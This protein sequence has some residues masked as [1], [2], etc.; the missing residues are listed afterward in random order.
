MLK[1]NF[2]VSTI[3]ALL[4]VGCGA[5]STSDGLSSTSTDITVERGPVYG[6]F[7]MDATGNRAVFLGDGK[8]RFTKQVVYPIT[9]DGGYIDVNRNSKID[10]GEIRLPYTLQANK[11]S[12][13]TMA[14]TIASNPQIRT[15]L[16]EEFGLSDEEIDTHTPGSN[17]DIAGLSDEVFAYCV[18]N[19]LT[20]LQF[21]DA[22]LTQIRAQIK[23][24]ITTYQD[25]PQSVAQLE[26]ELLDTLP[27]ETIVEGELS[28]IADSITQSQDAHDTTAISSI[29]IGELTDEQKA[30]LI[31][32]IEEEKLAR[33]VYEY[34]YA[35]W[36]LRIFS[37]ISRAEQ[38]HMNAVKII[39]DKY[40]LT[41]PATLENRGTY[42]DTHL[43]D[44]YNQL[45][46][47]GN[48]SL[49]DAL[50]VGKT[51]EDVDIA[52]L[53]EL[54]KDS[55][56]RDVEIVYTN[57]LKGSNNHLNAFTNQLSFRQ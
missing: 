13:I 3:T 42:E 22:N 47:K 40:S 7:V 32:M 2:I 41:P 19:N 54:M 56:P 55:I 1:K 53:E 25:S 21:S 16:E 24:R 8:Y 34:L 48:L 17:R 38:Q 11:G 44:L 43:Q 23:S 26:E 57:L 10:A 49:V 27:L 20:P 31:F 36:N 28:E 51:I 12:V 30:G 29:P 37:N 4:L 50:E 6:A 9:V 45:I 14:T 5:G 46:A 18:D 33:D 35:K 15:I 52:D 39:L